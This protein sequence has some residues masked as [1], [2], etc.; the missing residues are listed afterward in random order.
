LVSG[1]ADQEFPRSLLAEPGESRSMRLPGPPPRH[2]YSLDILRGLAALSVVFWHWQH[3]F[4]DRGTEPASLSTS[5]LPLY[6]VFWPLYTEGWRAVDL[7][8]CLSGFIFYW[9]YAEKIGKG[10][11]SAR[12]FSLLRFSRLYPLHLLMLILV[13]GGQFL[14]RARHGSFF[15]YQDNDAYHF[16]LQLF[17]ASNWG[18]ERGD[19]FDGPIWSVSLEVLLY[20]YFFVL[21]R[22]GLQRWWH[23]ALLALFGL[24][25]LPFA[26][27]LAHGVFCFFMGGLTYYAV[28]RL[29]QSGLSVRALRGIIASTVVAWLVVP[30]AI[31]HG[32][33]VR[34]YHALFPTGEPRVFGKHLFAAVVD[35][36]DF[37]STNLILFPMTVATL[38]LVEARR[39]SLGKRLS[40]LGQISYSSYLLHFPLQLGLV[41][42]GS[43]FAP[44]SRFYESPASLILFFCLLI[45]LSLG[46]YHLF[47]KPAQ[48][49]L[50]ARLLPP[51]G[52]KPGGR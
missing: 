27:V 1:A 12:E 6:G 32:L 17:L 47:E 25:L 42:V 49:L 43:S 38:A 37:L 14:F 26:F 16:V 19:S 15:V 8:F 18:L 31:F 29:L 9:L 50:R 24:L 22:L 23:L 45:P 20:F 44:G 48:F 7:F 10:L 5:R 11:V 2:F 33:L 13:A 52:P 3:F 28:D 4:F 21:C 36:V 30:P 51:T 39:G 41:L 34:A 46:S 40:F 35:Q